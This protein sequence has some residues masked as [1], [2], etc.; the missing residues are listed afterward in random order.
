MVYLTKGRGEWEERFIQ[1]Y[2]SHLIWSYSLHW[3]NS[4]YIFFTQKST[5]H[6]VLE[7]LILFKPS[8]WL[9]FCKEN[10]FVLG[11]GLQI[12]ATLRDLGQC[13]NFL[14]TPSN[15]LMQ[16]CKSVYEAA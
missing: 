5:L 15:K 10:A 6:L 14:P 13:Q 2:P 11:M 7:L 3:P 9:L 4:G 12:Y 8:C 16:S 1:I